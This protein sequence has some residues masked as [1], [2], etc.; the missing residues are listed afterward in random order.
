MAGGQ[1]RGADGL[2]PAEISRAGAFSHV[3]TPTSVVLAGL[4][5]RTW[6][7]GVW[8]DVSVARLE[9][10]KSD[11]VERAFRA[12]P[13]NTSQKTD[14]CLKWEGL[15]AAISQGS[16]TR[17]ENALSQEHSGR[18]RL[19]EVELGRFEKCK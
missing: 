15:P 5:K 12:G 2:R 4:E 11:R 19:E 1:E 7:L 6:G 18:Q 14:R 10:L 17:T 9:R 3:L 8:Q 13:G 16:H